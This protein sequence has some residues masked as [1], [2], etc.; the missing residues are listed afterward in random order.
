MVIDVVGRQLDARMI[1]V[2]GNVLDHFQIVKG[3][4]LP[5]CS[6]GIDQDGDGR[7]DHPSDPGCASAA[8]TIENPRCDDDLDNDG[9]GALDWDGGAAAGAPD[10]HCTSPFKDSELART[11]GLGVE[12]SL[13][14]SLLAALRRRARSALRSRT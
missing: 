11:C 6:D 13:V 4:A 14:M 3:A 5:V 10:P 12:L 8:G 2:S 9:D 7:F 1:G